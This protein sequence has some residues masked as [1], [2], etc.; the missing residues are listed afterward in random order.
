MIKV[1]QLWAS[2]ASYTEPVEV[3]GWVRSVRESKTIDFIELV[4]GSCFRPVQIVFDRDE[5]NLGEGLSTGCSVRVT[6]KVV[7]T[8]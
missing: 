2:P 1:K 3:R 4:D 6:G 7:L 8:P 5:R